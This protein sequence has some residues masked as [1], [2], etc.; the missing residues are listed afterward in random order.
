MNKFTKYIN[1]KIRTLIFK[2]L[3]LIQKYEI[4][5]LDVHLQISMMVYYVYIERV[6]GCIIEF[7]T[8]YGESAITIAAAMN[9]GYEKINKEKKNLYLVDSFEG[10]PKI[11]SSVDLLNSHV[12]SG[13]WKQGSMKGLNENLLKNLVSSHINNAGSVNVFKGL[14]SEFK[15]P[16]NSKISLI[17]MDGDLYQSAIDALDPLFEFKNISIGCVIMFDD[18]YCSKANNNTG[19]IRAWNELK[20]KY[21][22]NCVEY[23]TYG[24]HGKS[25]II[26]NYISK[27][28]TKQN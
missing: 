17:N 8:A 21:N 19:E 27:N 12:I 2:I 1:F 22:I 14:F 7:G 15:F 3:K 13:R 28:V 26:T 25:F 24:V 18:Y 10:L 23:K 16:K 6:E 20:V 5:T 4:L 9:E 11:D